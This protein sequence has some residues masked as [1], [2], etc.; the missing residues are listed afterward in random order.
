MRLV[1]GTSN[2][3]RLEVWHAGSWGSVCK[4]GF[5]A[6]DAYV[7]CNQLLPGTYGVIKMSRPFG[8]AKGHIWLRD[9]GCYGSEPTLHSCSHS[10][11][12]NTGDCDHSM[13]VYL[14]CLPQPKGEI[15]H[16]CGLGI[17]PPGAD[18]C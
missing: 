16:R 13:D 1:S 18:S 5:D 17:L 10:S 9:L 15:L 11:W 3:G 14:A 6:L 7:A 8:P 4:R 12:G 2:S